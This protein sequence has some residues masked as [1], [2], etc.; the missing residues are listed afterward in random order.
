MPRHDQV[1]NSMKQTSA[2]PA[3]A[4]LLTAAVMGAPGAAFAQPATAGVPAAAAPSVPAMVQAPTAPVPPAPPTTAP[5]AGAM[6]DATPTTPVLTSATFQSKVG[7]QK[8]AKIESH[9]SRLHAA[10]KIT[11]QQEPL[12]Q[13][14]ASVM[15]QNVVQLDSV[16]ARRETQ[17]GTMNAVQDL[18]SYAEVQEAL[19]HNV[20]MLLPPFQALYDSLSPD[21]KKAADAAFLQNTN[22]ALQKSG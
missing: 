21:Q 13:D 4:L 16:F 2:R 22:K 7:K 5:V 1:P 15:R 8:A 20:Q 3:L 19:A 6:S 18:Q 14:V 9:I 12:W 11:Q 17:Y 10:L